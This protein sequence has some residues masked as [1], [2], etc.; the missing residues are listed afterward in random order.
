MNGK[1]E[2]WE[3]VE[4]FR[5]QYLAGKRDVL[6]VD[7]LTLA[8]ID[9]GLDIIPFDD[10]FEKYGIDA[11]LTLDFTGIYVD[12]ESYIVWETGPLWKQHRL[13][14]S[15][16]HEL[17]QLCSSSGHSGSAKVSKFPGVLSL[18]PALR[19]QQIYAGTM[20]E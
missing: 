18:V 16:A 3:R 9:L 6:P 5:G 10:L 7:V 13:R 12:A 17:G 15:I 4:A 8:E 11:A 20:R 1:Q 2:V 14:F 19:R